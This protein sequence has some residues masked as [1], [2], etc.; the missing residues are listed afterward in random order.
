[1]QIFD[2]ERRIDHKIIELDEGS[3]ALIRLTECLVISASI[4]GQV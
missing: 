1:M 2:L 3:C 4:D